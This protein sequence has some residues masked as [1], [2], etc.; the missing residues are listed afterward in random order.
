MWF[1]QTPVD[2][3][4]LPTDGVGRSTLTGSVASWQHLVRDNTLSSGAR[5]AIASAPLRWSIWPWQQTGRRVQLPEALAGHESLAFMVR[6]APTRACIFV[7]FPKPGKRTSDG[8]MEVIIVVPPEH[9][10]RYESLVHFAMTLPSGYVGLTVPSP[11]LTREL[12]DGS[13]V[14]MLIDPGSDAVMEGME[15]LVARAKPQKFTRADIRVERRTNVVDA[16]RT[17]AGHDDDEEWRL[18]AAAP[19][20]EETDEPEDSAG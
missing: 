8:T 12:E 6:A 18:F 4:L 20:N 2:T 11:L 15:M 10:N 5:A 13:H 9:F 17:L 14:R 3:L 7:H 19:V 1:I 16:S